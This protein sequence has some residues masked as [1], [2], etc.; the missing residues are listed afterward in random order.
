[1]TSQPGGLA[2]VP[3]PLPLSVLDLVPVGTGVTPGDAI[4][5]SLD[6]ARRTEQ[7]GFT[8]YWLAEHHGMPG[9]AS[10]ATALLIGQVAAA[11]ETIRV[12]SG[13]VM[14]PNHA[15]LV[16]AEQFGTLGAMFP[17]RIDLGL[18][19]APGTDQA[20]ARALRRITGRVLTEDEF[21]D[22]LAELTTFLAGAEFPRGHR[23][24]GVTAFP[25]AEMP[26]IWLLGSSGYSAQVAGILSLPFAFAHHFSAQNTLPALELYRSSFRPSA[27]RERPYAMVAAAVLVADT[28]EHAQWL[29]GPIRLTM[30][31]LRTGRPGTYPTPEEAEAYPWTDQEREVAR[32]A[33]AS[34]VVGSPE[35]VRR[36]LRDLL[37]ATGAD[38]LMV[39]TNVH[40]HADRVHSYELLADLGKDL[41]ST[42]TPAGAV[43][44][45][46]RPT[47]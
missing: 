45:A 41:G 47:S 6:L 4:R 20:T 28:D 14:L 21:P 38:E 10:A 31:R 15:P 36:G 1:M 25:R 12:G 8:R 39:T 2:P 19:R 17:G 44:E 5:N 29:A 18:G 33:T 23:L 22:Q 13:G 46:A 7:L 42:R 43:S 37:D 26:P 16:V 27:G 34:H 24:H 30:M 9:I 3:F 32:Q 11:T 35:T 40:G